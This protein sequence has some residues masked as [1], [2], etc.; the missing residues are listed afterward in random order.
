MDNNDLKFNSFFTTNGK[1]IWALMSYCMYPTCELKNLSTEK[2]ESFGMGGHT[3]RRFHRIEMPKQALKEE[4]IPADIDP[5][6]E[7]MK[8]DKT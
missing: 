8:A 4:S 1:D 6:Y 5:E 3:A 7:A 2:V